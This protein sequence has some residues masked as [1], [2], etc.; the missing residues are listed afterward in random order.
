[1]SV[2]CCYVPDFLLTLAAPAPDA[3]TAPLALLG[4]DERI[5][6]ASLPARREGVRAEMRPQQ[7][8]ARCP[9]L[10]LLACDMTEAQATH[11]ALL[12]VLGAW[13]LPVET[14]SWGTAYLDLRSVALT[15]AAVQPLAAELGRQIRG[16]LG[17]A[18]QPA[19][20]WDSG[21]FTA[22]A[23]AT[24]VPPGRMRLVDK[25]QEVAF[26]A[27][28]PITLLPLP[29]AA[30]RRLH[31]LG[32]RTLGQFAALPPAAVRQRFGRAGILA[33]QWAQG[34]DTRA[35]VPTLAA[36]PR[37]FGLA[38][39][40]PSA[41]LPRVL[42]ELTIALQPV[43][44]DLRMRLQGISRL[45]LTL[46]FLCGA[47]RGLDLAVVRPIEEPAR[48][49]ALLAERLAAL[50]W[51]DELSSVRITISATAEL[52]M[53]QLALLPE[54]LDSSV[55]EDDK[56]RTP[57]QVLAG[58]LQGRY[59]GIF[60]EAQVDDVCHPIPARRAALHVLA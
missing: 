18:L 35:V 33:Q 49:H 27:P 8:L 34:R 56:T 51:P 37:T 59:G 57:L 22:R 12:N 40:P 16:E 4:A 10:R 2:L 58:E 41:S 47:T 31:W 13:A 23:A 3:L 7:A 30:C 15:G 29:V 45:R 1:M 42:T 9:D 6:A 32:I 50:I 24:R 11:A 36:P 28:L 21:K 46:D 17:T 53:G 20:G 38:I 14:A 54:L 55:P 19:L 5:C 25:V 26:L 43:L 44:E 48:L 39:D 60:F 52:P